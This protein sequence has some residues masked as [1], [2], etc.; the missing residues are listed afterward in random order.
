MI[1]T[2]LNPLD[3]FGTGADNPHQTDTSQ[4]FAWGR[5]EKTAGSRCR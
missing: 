5:R 2:I 1:M 4:S 3:P